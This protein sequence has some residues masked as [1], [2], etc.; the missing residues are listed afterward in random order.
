MI[1]AVIDTNVLVSAMLQ[2]T[3]PPGVVVE[4]ALRGVIQP[5]FN[6]AILIEYDR[7]LRRPKFDIVETEI[8]L[9]ID[10]IEGIGLE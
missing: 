4:L 5:V 6:R 1:S 8:R 10:T 7:V 9:M 3:G 2:R